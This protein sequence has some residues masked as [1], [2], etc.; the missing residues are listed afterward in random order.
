MVP[1]NPA[2]SASINRNGSDSSGSEISCYT[3]LQ[4]VR[5]ERARE[6]ERARRTAGFQPEHCSPQIWDI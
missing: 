4:A 6:R 1:K 2:T 3:G 5:L